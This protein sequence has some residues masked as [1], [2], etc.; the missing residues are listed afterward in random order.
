MQNFHAES[1][2]ARRTQT[3]SPFQTH[4]AH[5]R[6]PN[7]PLLDFCNDV[8]TSLSTCSLLVKLLGK[9]STSPTG[10][11]GAAGVYLNAAILTAAQR[12]GFQFLHKSCDAFFISSPSFSAA[13]L[14]MR[15]K[16]VTSAHK[17]PLS[18]PR[19]LLKTKYVNI[20][21]SIDMRPRYA[22]P[23]RLRTCCMA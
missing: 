7:P 22:P 21:S 15:R 18:P 23:Q 20:P 5:C 4:L 9:V 6:N 3:S 11:R 10:T 19:S 17:P 12:M 8:K 2:R 13:M 16:G 1:P 14:A